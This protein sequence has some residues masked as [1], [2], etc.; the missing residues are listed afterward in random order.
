MRTRTL[1]GFAPASRVKSE[2]HLFATILVA[3]CTLVFSGS[4][5]IAPAQDTKPAAQP[6]VPSPGKAMV[7]IY[8]VGRFV[9]SAAHDHLFING[10]YLAEL[11]NGEYAGMEVTPG[12]VVVT[13]MPKMYYGGIIQSTGAAMNDARTK[14]TERIRFNAEAGKTYYLKWTSETMATGIKVT[15]VDPAVGA[16]EMSKLHPSKPVEQP[17][18]KK[19]G[20]K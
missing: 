19:E 16:K 7:Y 10:V 15:P 13:G 20:E 4:L 11:L 5:T 17:V 2:F 3:F 12:A 9:G 1:F 6:T 18:A 14:E 8:R